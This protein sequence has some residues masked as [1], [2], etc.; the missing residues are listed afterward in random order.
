MVWSGDVYHQNS[1]CSVAWYYGVDSKVIVWCG[2][3]SCDTIAYA[4]STNYA[5]H[6]PLFLI[7]VIHRTL[8][9]I[10]YR[11]LK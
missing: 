3:V 11:A 2:V 9:A 5:P 7:T 10:L 1:V 6:L 8:L 4:F